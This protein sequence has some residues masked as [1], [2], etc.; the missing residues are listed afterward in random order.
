MKIDEQNVICEETGK[1]CMTTREAGSILNMFRHHRRHWNGKK[2]I[3]K[4]KYYCKIC[5]C[6]HLTHMSSYDD[7]KIRRLNER[8]FYTAEIIK[9]Y[10]FVSA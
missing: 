8:H 2:K 10:G 1:V 9:K 7:G 6:Y 4:R 3:P 5:R